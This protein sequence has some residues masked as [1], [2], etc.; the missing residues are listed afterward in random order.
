MPSPADTAPALTV[1]FDGSCP[2]CRREIAFYQRLRPLQ[3]I[4]W[5]DVSRGEPCGD[6]LTCELAMRRFH[7]RDAQGQLLDGAAAFARLWRSLPGWRWLGHVAGVPPVSWLAEGA[8][9]LFLPLRPRLQA[10]ARRD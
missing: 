5:V 9:R 7:V 4:A 2:L 3:P 8:Y 1:Y 10:W 6:G